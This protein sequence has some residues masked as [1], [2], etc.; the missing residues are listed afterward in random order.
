MTDHPAGVTGVWLLCKE[1][2]FETQRLM[3]VITLTFPVGE[4]FKFK[5]ETCVDGASLLAQLVKNP[6]VL[7]E[8]PV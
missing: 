4:V 7:Q 5:M 3:K 6:P 1:L 8:T 2:Y